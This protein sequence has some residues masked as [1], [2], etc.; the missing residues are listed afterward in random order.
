MVCWFLKLKQVCPPAVFVLLFLS[1]L[2]PFPV[3]CLLVPASPPVFIFPSSGVPPFPQ[4]DL[5][6]CLAP[7][8]LTLGMSSS[9]LQAMWYGGESLDHP[10]LVQLRLTEPEVKASKIQYWRDHLQ[11]GITNQSRLRYSH[12]MFGVFSHSIMALAV[13]MSIHHLVKEIW[14]LSIDK[15]FS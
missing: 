9:T 14:H 7:V 15:L 11:I 1:V 12:E 3:G 4:S 10:L 2:L 5:F 13:A 6:I 8:T